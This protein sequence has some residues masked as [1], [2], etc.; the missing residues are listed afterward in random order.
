M[1]SAL[2]KEY[3]LRRAAVENKAQKDILIAKKL[4]DFPQFKSAGDVLCYSSFGSEID[5]ARIIGESLALGKRLFLPKCL[6]EKGRMRFFLIASPDDLAKGA[7]GIAEPDI[8]KCSA[9]AGFENALCIVP[10]LSFDRS[11][12]RLGYGG[13]YYDRFL[14]ENDVISVGLCY[15]ELISNALPHESFDKSVDFVITETEII[16]P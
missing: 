3:K 9:A 12:F 13:G 5:T 4:L 16:A 14:A 6:G 1:K 2:R 8:H 15:N 11:G 7:Y 10:A